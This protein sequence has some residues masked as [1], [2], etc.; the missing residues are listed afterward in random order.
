MGSPSPWLKATR[1]DSLFTKDLS[2]QLSMNLFSLLLEHL[3]QFSKKCPVNSDLT[4][5]GMYVTNKNK[6]SL[7][8]F[9]IFKL[10]NIFKLY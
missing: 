10:L 7:Q 6:L 2:L 8:R 4:I 5:Y 3:H 1:G 9:L